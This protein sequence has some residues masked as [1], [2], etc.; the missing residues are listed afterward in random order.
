MT[1]ATS[2]PTTAADSNISTDFV[3]A[4]TQPYSASSMRRARG[5]K[6]RFFSENHYREL[7]WPTAEARM[8]MEKFL[9]RRRSSWIIIGSMLSLFVLSDILLRMWYP[10]NSILFWGLASL[11]LLA[12][13]G[14]FF[15]MSLEMATQWKLDALVDNLPAGWD[16]DAEGQTTETEDENE[17]ENETD[18]EKKTGTY[19]APLEADTSHELT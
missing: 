11:Y 8:E 17:D 12:F 10:D 2:D 16:D 19:A 4:S 1:N 5:K 18:D 7:P 14:F 13:F 15:G 3:L 9:K 6:R